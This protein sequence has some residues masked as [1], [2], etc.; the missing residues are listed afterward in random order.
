MPL[1][2][3]S[4]LN[5][6]NGFPGRCR[7]QDDPKARKPVLLVFPTLFSEGKRRVT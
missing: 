1:E 5:G 7:Y 2:N 6:L 4:H 3:V